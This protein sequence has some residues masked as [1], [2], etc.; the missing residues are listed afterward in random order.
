MGFSRDFIRKNFD[1]DREAF[2]F[3]GPTNEK[4]PD[5]VIHF[6][7]TEED[8]IDLSGSF[9]PT[10]TFSPMPKPLTPSS[11][12]YANCGSFTQNGIIVIT[13]SNSTIVTYPNGTQV[14]YSKC[15]VVQTLGD[16]G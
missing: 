5:G 16:A 15:E 3:D 8:D 2:V 9:I 12:T 11:G 4:P 14:L 1:R 7:G 6:P 10:I 13:S